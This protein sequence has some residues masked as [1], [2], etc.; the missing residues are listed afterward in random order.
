MRTYV[1]ELPRRTRALFEGGLGACQRFIAGRASPGMMRL[2]LV[3]SVPPS[4]EE[5]DAVVCVPAAAFATWEDRA[6]EVVSAW[7]ARWL[8]I[9]SMPRHHR[10]EARADLHHAVATALVA[11]AVAGVDAHGAPDDL[12]F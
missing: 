9:E 11:A 10:G 4:G 5:P 3:V 1:V 6:A 7:E 2:A 8:L 12:V